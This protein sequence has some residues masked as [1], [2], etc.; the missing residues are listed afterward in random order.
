MYAEERQQ[1]IVDLITRRGRMSVSDL[2]AQFAVTTETVRRDLSTLEDLR[3]VR[4]VHGGAIAVDALTVIETGLSD[5]DLLAPRREG[6]DRG[7]R[8]RPAAARG[9]HGAH[10]RRHHHRPAVRSSSPST[11]GSPSSPTQ[12]P[13]RCDSRPSPVSSC[14]CCPDVSAAPRRRPSAP[15]PSR[16]SDQIRADVAFVGTNG[17]TVRHGLSTPDRD[18]AATKPA[19]IASAHRV[20]VLAD[21]SKVGVERTRP[22]RRAVSDR[23]PRHRRRHRRRRPHAPS[24]RPAS[25]SWSRDR[26]PDPEPQHRPHRRAGRPAGPGRGAAGG[27]G[28]LPGRRQGRQHLPGG[29]HARASPPSPC[30]PPTSDDPFVLELLSAG[31]DCR[32]SP[33]A[34]EIRVNLTITEPDGTTTKLNSPGAHLDCRAPRRRCPG[35]CSTRAAV[36]AWVVLA[37]LA[38]PGRAG[39]LVRRPGERAARRPGAGGRR[40]QRGAARRAGRRPARVRT[41]PDEAQRRGA[42]V[43]HGRRR[44]A[45]RVRPARG[46]QAART[47]VDRGVGRGAGHA[48]R[49]RRRPGHRARAPGTPLLRRPPSSA[50]SVP[51]T[52]ACSAT[53][54]ATCATLRRPTAW[55]WRW[56][57]AAPPRAARHHDPRPG[58]GPPR[59]RRRRALDAEER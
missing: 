5:R 43:V 2:S 41:R 30:C 51:A 15:R 39:R 10:R 22:L 17:I 3:L 46:G 58:A 8:G 52:R 57:T 21:S 16:R 37:G 59:A 47:L 25:R 7:G 55:R 32:P 12:L 6:P 28:R 19:I 23:R 9:R 27:L 50:P 45:P 13:S 4:R 1:A 34:G 54:S 11:A 44:R 33:P 49:R 48:R 53:S 29:R 31:I 18:E 56:P 35:R 40:H 36:G 26:H 24:R 14:T 20:V 42:R 38:A